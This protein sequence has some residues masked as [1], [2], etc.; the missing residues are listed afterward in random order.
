MKR[1]ISNYFSR[2]I[3]TT[4][5]LTAILKIVATVLIVKIMY[6]YFDPTTTNQSFLGIF[7]L[8]FGKRCRVAICRFSRVVYPEREIVS[9]RSRSGGGM[10]SSEFAVAIKRTLERSIGMFT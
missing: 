8:R 7:L 10:V 2:Y 5:T 1:Q 4:F 3:K 9:I 6:Y